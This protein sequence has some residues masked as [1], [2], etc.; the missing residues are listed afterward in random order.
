[1][2]IAIRHKGPRSYVWNV[3]ELPTGVK[4]MA[5]VVCQ[6]EPPRDRAGIGISHSSYNIGKRKGVLM[7]VC[8]GSCWNGTAA[9]DVSSAR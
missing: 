5:D 6:Q 9:R 2:V 7:A 8:N 3:A 1:M 4:Q